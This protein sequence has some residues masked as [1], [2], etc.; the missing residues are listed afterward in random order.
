MGNRGAGLL[1]YRLLYGDLEVF[2]VHPGGPL[3]AKKDAGSWSIPKGEFMPGEEL[4]EV[5]RREFEE[6]MRLMPPESL[7]P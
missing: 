2:L 3:W 5:A 4:L 1:M 7:F 6:E